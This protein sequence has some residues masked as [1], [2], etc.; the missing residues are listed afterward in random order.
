MDG[1]G[2]SHIVGDVTMYHT[3]QVW[4]RGLGGLVGAALGIGLAALVGHWTGWATS[5]TPGTVAMALGFSAAVGVFFG[6]YPARR[7]AALDVIDAL[8]HQ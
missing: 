5:V 8:R 3:M 4:G 7:A 6:W 1:S 2:G